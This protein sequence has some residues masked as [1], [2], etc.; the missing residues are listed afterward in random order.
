MIQ[1]KDS[2]PIL[3]DNFTETYYR[4]EWGKKSTFVISLYTVK[5]TTLNMSK[6]RGACNSIIF[7]YTVSSMVKKPL[8]LT[9]TLILYFA[10]SY[11]YSPRI[12]YQVCLQH[13]SST[14]RYSN[15]M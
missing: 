12:Q 7:V 2:K 13:Q 9:L 10:Y 8:D 15:P 5:D 4:V 14:R 1:I 3:F 6:S 11:S